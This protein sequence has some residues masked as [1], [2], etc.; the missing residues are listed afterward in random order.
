MASHF[1]NL[2]KSNA[3]RTRLET[4]RFQTLKIVPRALSGC[5]PCEAFPNERRLVMNWDQGGRNSA[6]SCRLS[7]ANSPNTILMLSKAPARSS[8]AASRSTTAMRPK[9][10]VDAWLSKLK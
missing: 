6:V 5:D 3:A 8:K 2:C 7:E 9:S 4:R 1:A 10:A